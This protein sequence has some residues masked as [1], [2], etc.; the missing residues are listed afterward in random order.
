MNKKKGT[1][2][3]ISEVVV[4]VLIILGLT[5]VL[6]VF[7][8]FIL[9]VQKEI[10]ITVIAGVLTVSGSVL[11]LL[12]TKQHDK[13]LEIMRDLRNK[14][15]PVYI[16]FVDSLFS[17]M[18]SFKEGHKAMTQEEMALNFEKYTKE[19]MIWGSDEV[20]NSYK[21]FHSKLK[22]PPQTDADRLAVLDNF[23]SLILSIRKDLGYQNRDIAPRDLLSLFISD[24]HKIEAAN[25]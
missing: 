20:V 3:S 11:S 18:Y 13:Q 9:S 8:V 23:G 6:S 1:Q 4:V 16:G 14:K 17:A 2:Q 22:T 15:T 5:V 21:E 19:L 24:L 10:A 12:I 7:L 25:K